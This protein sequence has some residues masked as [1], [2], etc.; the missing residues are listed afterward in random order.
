MY[1]IKEVTENRVG[2]RSLYLGNDTFYDGFILF[3]LYLLFSRVYFL[4]TNAE[5]LIKLKHNEF[6]FECAP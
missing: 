4:F 6:H 2:F 1:L 5:K 3:I